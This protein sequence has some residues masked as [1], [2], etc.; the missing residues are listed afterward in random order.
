MRAAWN[1]WTNEQIT[2]WGGE[3]LCVCVCVRAWAHSPTVPLATECTVLCHQAHTSR[4]LAGT[5]LLPPLQHLALNNSVSFCPI[6]CGHTWT[7][8]MNAKLAVMPSVYRLLPKLRENPP[9]R[10]SE[11]SGAIWHQRGSAAF[12]GK[13]SGDR[14]LGRPCVRREGNITMGLKYIGWDYSGSG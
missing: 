14:P 8:T 4:G 12:V 2:G 5:H 3:C 7:D 11:I 9:P 13:T 1:E 10:T 6:I